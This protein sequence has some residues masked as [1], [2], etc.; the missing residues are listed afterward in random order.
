MEVVM[1]RKLPPESFSYYLSLGPGRSYEKVA[2][3]YGVD[4]RSVT[5]LAAREGWAQKLADAER[6]MRE[7]AEE[8]VKEST[9]A[10]NLR[11]LKTV[12]LV[13][14]KA[15]DALRTL[16]LDTGIEA[17][18]ALILAV[19]KERLI[20]GEPTDRVDVA[21]IIKRECETLILKPGDEEDWDDDEPDAQPEQEDAVPSA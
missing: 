5:N 8:K 2:Q 19:D 11:H 6:E 10:M 17:V 18:R 15:L 12:Q 4:K 14:K 16:P 9:N 1:I 7:R 20:R 21:E 3:N 13:Q